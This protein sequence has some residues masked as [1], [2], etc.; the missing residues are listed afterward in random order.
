MSE[1]NNTTK[2][3]S[4]RAAATEIPSLAQ[5]V[6]NSQIVDHFKK[7]LERPP[8]TDAN[9]LVLGKP[10]TGK[11]A[12]Q[13]AYIRQRLA[14]PDLFS[15]DLELSTFPHAVDHQANLWQTRT[16]GK[17]YAFIRIDGGTDGKV[18]LDRKVRDALWNT[19][20]HTFV[21]LDEAGELFFRGMEECLRPLLTHPEITTYANAQNFHDRRRTDTQQEKD[22]RLHAFLRRFEYRFHTANPSTR[23]LEA[24]L[25]DR[26]KRW[27]I[28]LD[29]INTL[30][31]IVL[32][33]G[34]VVGYALKPL[35]QAL[36][37]P[38]RR[39]TRELV[40][41]CDLDPADA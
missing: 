37:Q 17:I 6:G 27:C 3:L 33:S 36:D 12:V 4:A 13:L 5:I 39:L 28:K 18:D 30:R 20:E 10:G 25:V 1:G 34:G 40:E 16:A 9:V 24:C 15:G 19:A 35:I 7:R 14:N 22:A 21:L 31:L 11:S 32:K 38:D 26:L 8:E 41:R 29:S 23:E 2:T